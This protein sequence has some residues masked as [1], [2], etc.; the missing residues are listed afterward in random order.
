MDRPGPSGTA[1]PPWRIWEALLVV[2]LFALSQ[3]LISLLASLLLR[4]WLGGE[5][6]GAA[7]E[8]HLIAVVLPMVVVLSHGVGWASLYYLILRRHHAR[9]VPALRLHLHRLPGRPQLRLGRV[10]AAGMGLQVMGVLL[11]A[12]VGPPV[13]LENPIL[14]FIANG[15]WTVPLL[16][17]MAVVM[18]PLLEECLFRGVLYPALRRRMGF[19]PAAV[20]VTVLFTAL[21]LFQTDGFWVGLLAIAAA[22]YLM[23]WLRERNDSLWPSIVFHLGF[24]LT[25]VLP[26][27]FLPEH[28][29]PGWP[30]LLGG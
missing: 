25:A 7:L 11:A 30:G 15:R 22:G 27:V 29:P 17:L 8:R 20:W 1:Y 12:L 6:S 10:L 5:L 14:R 18:A 13:G 16:F 21:H 9:F 2:A 4:T 28:L 23:A 19:V 24:N 26:L 3:P